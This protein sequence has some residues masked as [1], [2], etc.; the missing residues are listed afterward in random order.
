MASQAIGPEHG[1]N[2]YLEIDR[3]VSLEPSDLQ[4][5]PGTDWEKKD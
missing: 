4:F 2:L 5:C 1:E 3:L